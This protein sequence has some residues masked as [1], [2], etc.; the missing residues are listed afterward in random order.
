[1][2]SGLHRPVRMRGRVGNQLTIWSVLPVVT[3]V[4]ICAG[5][6]WASVWIILRTPTSLNT[7][8]SA[9]QA[10]AEQMDVAESVA[11]ESVA[12]AWA[13]DERDDA[14][15]AIANAADDPD[16]ASRWAVE[17]AAD[18]PDM[19]S[20]W[21]VAPPTTATDVATNAAPAYEFD[22][23]A[24]GPLYGPAVPDGFADLLGSPGAVAS[25]DGAGE[26]VAENGEQTPDKALEIAARAEEVTARAEGVTARAE[27]L[28]VRIEG[29]TA[30]IEELEGRLQTSGA[31]LAA[32]PA[33]VPS[34]VPVPRQ[35]EIVAAARAGQAQTGTRAPWVVLPQP[36][37]GSR[38]TAGPLVLEARARGEAP[39]TQIRLL[40]D[41]VA[42]SVALEKRDDTTWR[43]RA[44]TRVT[45]GA[46]TVAVSVVDGQGRIGSYRWQFN[47]A[48]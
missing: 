46:H 28:T 21:A 11:D 14:D 45:P 38:V 32:L 1:V 3:I 34:P 27:E 31:A 40:L 43:G 33:L 8:A 13:E 48:S 22:E 19:R 20:V 36:E 35:P 30:R 39:I 10:P 16:M 23:V 41:G 18:E 4:I 42:L 44:S 2:Q 12:V 24:L 29:L 7:V 9:E 25:G 15:A 17:D 5:L 37:P 47:A 26:P 6:F